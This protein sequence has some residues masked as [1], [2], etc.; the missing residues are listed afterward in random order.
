VTIWDETNKN[1]DVV[2]LSMNS[3]KVTTNLKLL[4]YTIKTRLFG[5]SKRVEV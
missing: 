2:Y 4:V 3:Y 1:R 5:K